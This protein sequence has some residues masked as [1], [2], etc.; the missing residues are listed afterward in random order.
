MKPIKN[1]FAARDSSKKGYSVNRSESTLMLV[2][3]K[4][5]EDKAPVMPAILNHFDFVPKTHIV[6]LEIVALGNSKNN[7]NIIAND[8]NL[9]SM[10]R[11][12]DF[13]FQKSVHTNR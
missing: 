6:L 9:L 8:V 2:A 13:F 11:S 3:R 12:T 1:V 10:A 4:W 7:R 5:D